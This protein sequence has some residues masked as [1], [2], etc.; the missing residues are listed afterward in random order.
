MSS[1]S[2]VALVRVLNRGGC[3][4]IRLVSGNGTFLYY[5]RERLNSTSKWRTV[6]VEALLVGVAAGDCAGVSSDRRR[7]RYM[8]DRLKCVRD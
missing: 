3:R 6:E 7:L 2:V 5:Y 1:T 4:G 8:S